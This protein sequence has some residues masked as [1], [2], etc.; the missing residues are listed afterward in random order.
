[1]RIRARD[2]ETIFDLSPNG[3]RL[4][5][6]KGI[7]S[8][9][10][11]DE[12]GYRCYTEKELQILARSMQLR[13]LGYSIKE[14]EEILRCAS[15]EENEQRHALRLKEIEKE[16]EW[17]TLLKRYLNRMAQLRENSMHLMSACEVTRNPGVY[18]FGV[19]RGDRSLKRQT[20]EDM[21]VWLSR[22]SP[23]LSE[24]YLLD[25][26]YIGTA[27]DAP[28]HTSWQTGFLIDA[29]IA[30][31]MGLEPCA[32]SFY[33][34]PILCLQTALILRKPSDLQPVFDRVHAHA[35]S[36]SLSLRGGGYIR[37]LETWQENGETMLLAL[38]L[39]QLLV[40]KDTGGNSL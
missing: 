24:A 32:S 4:Y 28:I 40:P 22:Y 35:Q 10:R 39:A 31:S 37:V 7:L 20:V 16:I 17:L 3:L 11:D 8:P 6:D 15:L 30:L 1:M 14:T 23:F 27:S 12:N 18:F 34:P 29:D 33:L 21:K 9:D 25:G 13:R 26:N 2:M 19:R 36:Q 38:L 5:E